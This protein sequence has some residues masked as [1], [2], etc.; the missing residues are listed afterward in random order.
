ME[1][2]ISDNRP[3]W[4][5]LSE[6]LSAQIAAG[7]FPPGGRLPSVRDFAQEA[8]VNPNTMQRALSELEGTGLII[9][10]RTAGRCVT[11]DMEV[12][13]R[14]KYLRA[15]AE[16]RAFLEKMADLGFTKEEIGK[17]LEETLK[18]EN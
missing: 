16:I 11:E 7:R 1:W 4:L 10:N 13:R 9:T 14:A 6:Q 12:I 17:V 5:Q 8:G 3:I 18:E 15:R 2:K